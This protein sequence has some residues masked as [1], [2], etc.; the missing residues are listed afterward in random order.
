MRRYLRYALLVSSGLAALLAVGFFWQLPWAT[1]L[2]PWPDSRLSYIF[3]ASIAAAIGAPVLWVGLTGEYS[4]LRGGA[5]NL[6]ITHTGI[7]LTTFIQYMGDPA[8]GVLLLGVAALLLL[9]VS[10]AI[11]WI[12]RGDPGPDA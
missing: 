7:A 2:W 10:A 12:V 4:A 11:F 8:P 1:G 6:A 9:L 3:L 5:L